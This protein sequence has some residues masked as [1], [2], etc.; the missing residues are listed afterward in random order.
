MNFISKSY[1]KQ[2][3]LCIGLEQIGKSHQTMNDSRERLI[4]HNTIQIH[5]AFYANEMKENQ[6][7][8]INRVFGD[9]TDVK[10]VHGLDGVKRLRMLLQRGQ[11]D[12][13]NG[14]RLVISCIGNHHALKEILSLVSITDPDH[15]LK[16]D[17]YIDEGDT[18][19]ID[20]DRVTSEV[21]KDNL[22]NSIAD[23]PQVVLV[24]EIT[25]TPMSQIVS[26][27]NYTKIYE[28]EGKKGYWGVDSFKYDATVLPQDMLD[29][30]KAKKLPLKIKE[31]ILDGLREEGQLSLVSTDHRIKNQ[32]KMAQMISR[33]V[34]NSAPVV[35]VNSSKEQHI[36]VD[37]KIAGS[38]CKGKLREIL[39]E[40]RN[41]G[42]KN[43]F[44]IGQRSLN[45][46]V[47]IEDDLKY[48]D[49]C[50]ILF[51]TNSG[52]SDPEVLQRV[53]RIAG[54]GPHSRVITCTSNVELRIRTAAENRKNLVKE[55][56]PITDANT[57]IQVL[58]KYDKLM[59][60]NV[61]GK[62][63]NRFKLSKIYQNKLIDITE[64]PSYP[65]INQTMIFTKDELF[66]DVLKQV[67]LEGFKATKGS[68]LHK[69]IL[70][71]TTA[72][73]VLNLQSG[74]KDNYTM[75]IPN[76]Y[77]K[78]TEGYR[79]DC[80]FYWNNDTLS[81]SIQPKDTFSRNYSIKCIETEKYRNYKVDQS[82]SNG[83]V[84]V[85]DELAA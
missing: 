22:I 70:A 72:E 84:R 24:K 3:E 42:F 47:T 69:F 43:V 63:N 51:N 46:S 2:H 74:R 83:E 60:S 37:G 57:R 65:V 33:T 78:N 53:S 7:Y 35:V 19:G 11:V 25:A 61:F 62:R 67:N 73:N 23:S 27:S 39:N 48:Y 45:R 81:V 79:R 31:W 59:K 55:V 64:K 17:V 52:S 49:A 20:H 14:G 36:Y 68:P 77:T 75:H 76:I 40:C 1:K 9:L 58:L 38:L 85:I 28:I 13:L 30:E 5:T 4:K 80:L 16:F 82:I 66:D 29:F 10:V 12:V 21:Q 6:D 56:M 41:K 34:K 71:H 8:H 54:Y 26:Q 50:R 32:I 44:V 15:G 18:Y